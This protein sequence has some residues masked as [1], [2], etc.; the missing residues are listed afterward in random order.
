MIRIIAP[1]TDCTTER[2]TIACT[3]A[4]TIIDGI[5]NEYPQD[6]MTIHN[7]SGDCVSEISV[8]DGKVCFCQSGKTKSYSLT[9]SENVIVD[10][11]CNNI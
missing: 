3:V 2:A 7:E 9:D 4:N 6:V 8:K 10:L 1:G 11:I 5:Y